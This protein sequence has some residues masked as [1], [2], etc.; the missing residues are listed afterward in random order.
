[1]SKYGISEADRH[2]LKMVRAHLQ[3]TFADVEIERITDSIHCIDSTIADLA[4][5]LEWYVEMSKQ[6]GKAAIHQD[7]KAMLAMMHDI[8]IDY[9]KR[10]SAALEKARVEE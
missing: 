9:G 5:A 2:A 4:E 10:G 3:D 1:M 7:S 6:M 8:A